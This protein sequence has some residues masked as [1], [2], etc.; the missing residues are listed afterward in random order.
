MGLDPAD[1]A[2]PA[3]GSEEV[4]RDQGRHHVRDVDARLGAELDRIALPPDPELLQELAI[5]P[6]GPRDVLIHGRLRLHL[7]E[8]FQAQFLDH[9]SRASD[10]LAGPLRTTAGDESDG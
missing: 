3:P 4:P 6:K 9:P 5:D 1:I 10:G 2:T 8:T 7:V